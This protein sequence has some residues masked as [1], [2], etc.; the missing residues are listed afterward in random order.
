MSVTTGKVHHRNCERSDGG[1]GG[2]RHIGGH[3]R[4]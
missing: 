3:L 2:A 4:G 1:S